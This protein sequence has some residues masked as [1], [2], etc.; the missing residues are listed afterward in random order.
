MDTMATR[1]IARGIDD[2]GTHTLTERI[3]ASGDHFYNV[4]QGESPMGAGIVG[5]IYASAVQNDAG[6]VLYWDVYQ[7]ASWT[8]RHVGTAYSDSE[9]GEM[10]ADA[11][12]ALAQ[13]HFTRLV[14]YPLA[15]VV[16][17]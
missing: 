12:A 15:G 13:T 3:T 2:Y 6:R 17:S 7:T 10:V 5:T 4:I 8:D 11:F 9:R 16:Q 1:V 14:T